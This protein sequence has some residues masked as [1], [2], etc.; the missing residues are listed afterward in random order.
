M[1]VCVYIYISI[2]LSIYIYICS[3]LT[4]AGWC[5]REARCA[6]ATSEQKYALVIEHGLTRYMYRV[7]PIYTYVYIL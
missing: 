5:L 1:Y 7:N 3:T 2:Y 4:S 6:L